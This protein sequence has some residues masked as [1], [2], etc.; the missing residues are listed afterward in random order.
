[1]PIPIIS[2]ARMRA[3]EQAT[4]AAGTTPGAV[5]EQ[6]GIRLAR[7]LRALSRPGDRLLLLAG[8]GHNGDDVRAA[9]PHLAGR[10]VRLLNLTEPAVALP[11]LQAALA[12]APA[13]VVDGLFGIGLNRPLAPDW[14]ALIEALN[15]AGRPILAVDV[16]SGLNA[17]TG[18]NFGAVVNATL[19]LTVG[20]P[21]N[22]LLAPAAWESV[23]RLEVEPD[24]GLI[25][26]PGPGD[27][28]WTLPGDF[29]GY[30]PP[31]PVASH[32]GTFGHLGIIAGSEGF[33]GAA[34]LAARG[35]QRARPGLIT[36]LTTPTAYVPVASQLQSVMVRP[37]RPEV[38]WPDSITAWVVGPGLAG[39]DVPSA[40]REAVIRLWQEAPEP[41]MADAS[42]LDWIKELAGPATAVRVITPHP[43]E[44]AR[45]LGL[46]VKA[47]QSARPA[48]VRTL[49]AR[50]GN[51][52]VVL[53]GHQSLV[54]QREG[55]LTVNP[56]GNA[57]LAQGGSG[58]LLA[59]LMGG[60]LAQPALQ[61]DPGRAVRYAVWRHGAAADRLAA[62]RPGW[63]IEELAA[64]LGET[65][66]SESCQTHDG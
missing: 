1:M 60:L 46:N 17:D 51:A 49:S 47:V 23:G 31:R 33:H 32:K 19:T 66:G 2:I 48:A 62:T 10:E 27:W 61:A 28:Q 55:A 36:L 40:M 58:D 15:A 6:V 9:L 43:G 35:A 44:A 12:E 11:G 16:P 59:G 63:T 34:V 53:K 24:I 14:I 39:P 45:L 50:N 25:D 21:K 38:T 64:S 65:V 5:I 3:W 20:A 8:R 30:P 52:W 26:S 18:E 54:G 37:W 42:A 57:G 41:V 29:D 56:S 13:W 22:G 4:W 7:R